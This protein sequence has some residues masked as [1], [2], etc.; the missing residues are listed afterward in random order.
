MTVLVGLL[1][2]PLARL[3]PRQGRYGRVIPVVLFY[4]VYANLLIWGRAMFDKGAVP[5]WAGLWWVHAVML[6]LGLLYIRRR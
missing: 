2:V 4:A 1:A 5:E 3:R 6:V